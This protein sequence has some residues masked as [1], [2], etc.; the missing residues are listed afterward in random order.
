MIDQFVHVCDFIPCHTKCSQSQYRKTVVC[1]FDGITP[2]LSHFM[3]CVCHIDCV[4]HCIFYGTKYI[5]VKLKIV[6]QC[7]LMVH[8]FLEYSTCHL[9]N[10]FSQFTH[11][12]K[13]ACVY[14][15][16]QVTRGIFYD[17]PCTTQNQICIFITTVVCTFLRYYCYESQIQVWYC[18]KVSYHLMSHFA[19]CILFVARHVLF[20]LRCVSSLSRIPKSFAMEHSTHN[21]SLTCMSKTT[22]QCT[23]NQMF[24]QM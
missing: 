19:R 15:K 3:P 1:I 23:H 18:S 13:G 7:S 5:R 4:N 9:Y 12:P 2:L 20:F 24:D 16:R 14:K 22:A 21:L 8:V 11:S 6:M 10:V 17:I